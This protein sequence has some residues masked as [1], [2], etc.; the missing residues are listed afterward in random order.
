ME[1]IVLSLDEINAAIEFYTV[2]LRRAIRAPAEHHSDAILF[3]VRVL[4]ELAMLKWRL[5]DDDDINHAGIHWV[6]E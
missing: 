3:S 5:G 4:S 6:A 1:K 2:G